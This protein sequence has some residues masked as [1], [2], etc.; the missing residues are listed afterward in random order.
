MVHAQYFIQK[1]IQPKTPDEKFP[2]Y[3][4][5]LDDM[6]ADPTLITLAGLPSLAAAPSTSSQ[7]RSRAIPTNGEGEIEDTRASDSGSHQAAT[8]SGPADP[9]LL[10]TQGLTDHGDND[11]PPDMAR[12]NAVT[13]FVTSHL[14]PEPNH[15][16]LNHITAVLTLAMDGPV[17]K[18]A[19]KLL[20]PA[21]S[22]QEAEAISPT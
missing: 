12:A 20:T 11:I 9:A 16:R 3:Q 19:I 6:A 14:L 15:L 10:P 17:H 1:P 18:T 7:K 4:K 5:L 22:Q 8:T 2:D 13:A 21:Y